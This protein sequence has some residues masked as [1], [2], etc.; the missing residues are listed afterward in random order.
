[1]AIGG[2]TPKD[3]FVYGTNESKRDDLPQ[4]RGGEF[5]TDCG[6]ETTTFQEQDD[7]Y[8]DA[9]FMLLRTRSGR[10][11]L[12]RYYRSHVNAALSTDSGFILE[13]PTLRAHPDWAWD[14]D[15]ST[16][17][18]DAINSAAVELA[19]SIADEF[20]TQP[21]TLVTSG[22]IGSRHDD[23]ATQPNMTIVEAM[24]YHGRQVAAFAHA[25]ADM[26]TATAM[27][28]CDE[29]V[30][31]VRAARVVGIPVAVSFNVGG[32]GR[33]PTGRSLGDAITTVDAATGSAPV[34]YIVRCEHP[35]D[36]AR[37][38]DT[39]AE[40]VRRVRGLSV[41]SSSRAEEE[42]SELVRRQGRSLLQHHSWI[43]VLGGC[44]T[45]ARIEQTAKACAVAAHAMS[46]ESA[47]RPWSNH[48]WVD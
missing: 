44:T 45:S 34:Y 21:V 4:L 33:L 25:R 23:R 18:L 38:L 24:E 37:A 47:P 43:N 15:V 35:N 11:W 31:I 28:Q 46:T 2:T 27:A 7:T 39:Q 29:A 22:C 10:Q 32:D 8:H 12:K 13:T 1:M 9:A 41:V 16:T 30:G 5:L 3:S 20:A 19:R 48:S 42:V 26:I 40:W 14:F 36:A 6:L 17:E